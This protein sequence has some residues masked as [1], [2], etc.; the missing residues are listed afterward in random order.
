MLTTIASDFRSNAAFS[1]FDEVELFREFARSIVKHSKSTFIDETHGGNVCNVSFVSA[2]SK[3]ETCEIADLLIIVS[4]AQSK[5]LRATFW[6]AKKQ[7]VSKWLNV[8]ANGSQLDFKGQFNQWDLLSRRPAIT[9]TGTFNPPTDLLSCFPSPSIGSFGV[10]F[11]RNLTIELAHSTAEF[12]SCPSPAAKHPTLSINGYFDKYHFN[13]NEIVTR[14][15]L[16]DF[17]KS[18]F[19][20]EVGALLH[21]GVPQHQWLVGKVRSKV[22]AQT[23]ADLGALDAFISEAGQRVPDDSSGFSGLSVLFIGELNEA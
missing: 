21:P 7:A 12:I 19:N 20:F 2:T 18:L 9:G 5:K 13:V 10:F 1:K 17:L 16:A 15:N 11:E 23:G 6:Q 8:T 22:A 4:H 3:T 14:S